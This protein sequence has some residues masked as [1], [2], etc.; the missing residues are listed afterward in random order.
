MPTLSRVALPVLLLAAT[1]CVSAAPADLA[2]FGRIWTGDSARPFVQALAARGDT[3]VALGDSAAIARLVGERTTVLANG[4]G[5]VTPGFMDD[6]VHFLSGGFQLSS[7]DL[8]SADS[9]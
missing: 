6:H 1:G 5:L 7:V 2:V 4:S 8:R 3:I 9:P